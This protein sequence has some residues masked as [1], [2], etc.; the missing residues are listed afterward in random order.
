MSTSR[1]KEPAAE[2]AERLQ[3]PDELVVSRWRYVGGVERI[4]YNVPVTVQDGA[5]VEW[6]GPPAED[7]CWELADDGAEVTHLPDNTSL[8]EELELDAYG[9]P[10]IAGKSISGPATWAQT[11]PAGGDQADDLE[12]EQQQF[13]LDD[14]HDTAGE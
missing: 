2:A 8:I 14:H 4:Y 11:L 13:A 3:V 1:R 9:H 5:V 10:A 6:A 7:G 12:G